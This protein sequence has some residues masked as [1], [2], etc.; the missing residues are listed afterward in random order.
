MTR[1]QALEHFK[2]KYGKDIEN[3]EEKFV[4]GLQE[5]AEEVMRRILNAFSEIADMAEEKEKTVC[6]FFFFSLLRYELTQNMAK[7]RLDVMDGNWFL[8]KEPLDA[9]LD[10]T[11]LFEPYFEQKEALLTAMREYMGKVNQYDVE[12]IIQEKIMEAGKLLSHFLRILFRSIECQEEF[13]RIPKTSF[14]EIRFGEY[15]DSGEVIIQVNRDERNEEEWLE[16]LIKYK[17]KESI[18]QSS[19]WSKAELTK[20]DCKKKKLY[21]I[22][23]ENCTLKNINFEKSG[24]A[25]ARFLHCALESCSF[26][27]ADLTQ[28]EFDMCSFEDCNFKD[29]VLKQALFSP[30]EFPIECFDEKQKEEMMIVEVIEA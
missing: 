22:V 29:A 20:G 4:H 5:N 16:Q 26:E 1:S 18:L 14:W 23:F 17:E 6:V 10:L 8:D 24:L 13:E 2:D 30:D 12:Y 28:A 9:Q 25:G 3:A 19:W 11:F 15:R 27:G 7:V 21:Y